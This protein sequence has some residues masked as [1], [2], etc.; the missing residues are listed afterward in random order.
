MP[1]VLSTVMSYAQD[2]SSGAIWASVAVSILTA[3]FAKKCPKD[4]V[5]V[6]I[7]R[8]NAY[9]MGDPQ[10]PED[11]GLLGRISDALLKP[12]TLAGKAF[13]KLV[14]TKLGKKAAE[15]LEEGIFVTL[16]LWAEE[17]LKVVANFGWAVLELLPKTVKAF[18]DGMVSDNQ[19]VADK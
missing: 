12:C 19:K 14:L 16:C 8:F 10:K 17:L 3:L 15:R 9:L 13:S 11:E 2:L 18:S 4:K 7:K 1:D 5:A 6:P